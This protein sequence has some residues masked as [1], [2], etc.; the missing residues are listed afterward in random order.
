[1]PRAPLLLALVMLAALGARCSFPWGGPRDALVLSGSLE[2]NDVRVGSLLGGRV[3][4]VFAREGDSVRVG[5][6][7]LTLD[8]ALTEEQIAEQRGRVAETRARL[9]LARR[10]PRREDVSKARVEYEN[11]ESDRRR[12]EALL[13][14]SVVAPQQ[15]ES[16]ATLAA[17]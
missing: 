6:R 12:L 5:D 9:D 10:G 4:S 3:D 17:S 13:R 14:D 1:M 7:L 15:Y 2:A 16:A 11:A 8:A